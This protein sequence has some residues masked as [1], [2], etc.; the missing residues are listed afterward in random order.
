MKKQILSI[1]LLSFSWISLNAQVKTD[2][3]YSYNKSI[4]K[5]KAMVACAHPLAAKVGQDILARGGNAVDAA[6]AMQFALAVVYPQ[7]GN[8]GGG[9]FMVYRAANGESNTLDYREIAPEK[10]SRDMYLDD[11]KN[12]IPL[13]SQNGH[14][15]SG[16][17]GSVAGMYESYLKYSKLKNWKMLVKPAIELAKTG[18]KITKQEADNLN[19]F[20]EDFK[21]YNTTSPVFVKTEKWNPGD[22]LIQKD[23][24][25][26]L[27]LIM[28]KGRDGFYKGAVARKIVAEMSL[29]KGIITAKDLAEYKAVW[30]APLEG[31]YKGYD[32]ISMPPPSSGGVALF[33]LLGMIERYP[34]EKWGFHDPKTIQV[35]VEAERRAY[36]DRAKFLGDPEFYQ[37]PLKSLLNKDYIEHRAKNL[38]QFTTSDKVKAGILIFESDQTTHLSVVDPFGNAV[39]L[40]TTLN[41]SYGSKTVVSGAGFILNNEMDDFSVKPGS[42]NLYGLIGGEANAIQPKK[43]MLSSMTPTIISKNGKLFMVT[44]TPGGSTIITSVFQTIVNVIDFKMTGTAATHAPRFHHQWQPDLIYIE[45]NNVFDAATIKELELLGYKIQERGYI[46]RE[47]TILVLPDGKLEGAADIRGDDDAEGF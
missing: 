43:R 20:Q 39:S 40:T 33:Q 46:G 24:A 5:D 29:G 9:G 15:A 32:L 37:V 4:I 28:R 30:R 31:K 35:M 44:G 42:P 19:G 17:P 36:A 25:Q 38:N 18:F 27:K 47:E 14:L 2:G 34:L 16:V 7:A 6:I 1:I 11:K 41:G 12:V 22:V 10:A 8:I 45:R 3:I 26:T 21:K 23:L 13:L